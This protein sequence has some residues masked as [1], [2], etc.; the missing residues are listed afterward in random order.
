MSEGDEVEKGQSFFLRKN[1]PLGRL[2]GS[3]LCFSL[4]GS[5]VS[6]QCHG[7]AAGGELEEKGVS[8][9]ESGGLRQT[10]MKNLRRRGSPPIEFPSERRRS[11]FLFVLRSV[12]EL[13]SLSTTHVPYP[14]SQLCAL[15]ARAERKKKKQ[16]EDEKRKRK[17][18]VVDGGGSGRKEEAVHLFFFSPSLALPSLK[19]TSGLTQRHLSPTLAI[20]GA[21]PDMVLCSCLGTKKRDKNEQEKRARRTSS[22]RATKRESRRRREIF[23]QRRSEWKKKLKKMLKLFVE[24]PNPYTH[25]PAL[26]L[27]LVV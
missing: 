18:G 17:K 13:R 27:F 6:R 16:S 9:R 8:R 4:P 20:L 3:F 26:S 19:R 2:R 12:R 10:M 25:A 5:T 7:S 1:K 14:F 15:A 24:A 22:G 11:L 21:T 23:P